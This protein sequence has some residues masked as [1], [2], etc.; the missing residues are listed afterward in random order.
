MVKKQEVGALRKGEKAM[1]LACGSQ[2]ENDEK[3]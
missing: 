1:G 3:P 2:L